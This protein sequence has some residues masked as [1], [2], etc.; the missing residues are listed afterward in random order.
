VAATAEDLV[1][2]IKAGVDD[3]PKAQVQLEDENDTLEPIPIDVTSINP[4]QEPGQL[5]TDCIAFG[6]YFHQQVENDP[7][8]EYKKWFDLAT[9]VC[10]QIPME[11][12][13]LCRTNIESELRVI[14]LVIFVL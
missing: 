12:Y 1:K 10:E 8:G 11:F 13:Q 14:K 9:A 5:C 4:N 7:D 2:V 6:T 3:L